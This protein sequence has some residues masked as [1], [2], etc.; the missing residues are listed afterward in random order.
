MIV[1]NS[2]YLIVKNPPNEFSYMIM[3]EIR[4]CKAPRRMKSVNWESYHV[5]GTLVKFLFLKMNAAILN[6]KGKTKQQKSETILT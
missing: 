4:E 5:K 2:F 1:K 6:E 3:S